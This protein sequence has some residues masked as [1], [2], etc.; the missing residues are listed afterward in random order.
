LAK[1]IYE[2]YHHELASIP[3]VHPHFGDS[4]KLLPEIVAGLDDAPALFWLDGHWSGGETA[5][6]GQECPVVDE[7]NCLKHRQQDLILIDDARMFLSAPPLPHQPEQWPTIA[8]IAYLVGED[9]F[10][11]VIDDVIF[12]V[13]QNAQIKDA[14]I[15]YAQAQAEAAIQSTKVP[16]L[17]R[18]ARKLFQRTTTADASE[19]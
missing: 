6:E 17:T 8:E 14:L 16:K 3:G 1:E 13:G 7:L 19:C 12:I 5:G 11:Q 15:G 18:L 2:T 10:V 4:A 9:R